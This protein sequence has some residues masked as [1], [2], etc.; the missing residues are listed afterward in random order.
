MRSMQDCVEDFIRLLYYSDDGGRTHTASRTHLPG[1][2]ESQLLELEDEVAAIK[3]ELERE[4]KPSFCA[5]LTK[6]SLTCSSSQRRLLLD[7]FMIE[8]TTENQGKTRTN[9]RSKARPLDAKWRQL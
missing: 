3:E 8:P 7:R 6:G 2:D 1:V 4:R 5:R 9:R